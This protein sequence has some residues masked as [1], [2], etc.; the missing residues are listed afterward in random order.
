M[1]L[2]LDSIENGARALGLEL[3][4]VKAAC[5]AV[6]SEL[7]AG[8]T[9]GAVLA[10][11]HR[12]QEWIYPVGYADPAPERQI[13]VN[14]DTLYD[15]ASLT[16]VVATLPLILGLIDEGILTL[17]T[18][19]SSIVPDF[20][21]AGKEEVTVGELLTHTSG[22]QAHMNLHSH[23]W[24]KEQMW[25]AVHQATLVREPRTAV[26]YSDL[27]YL[28]L[29]RVIEQVLGMSIGEAARIRIFEPLEMKHTSFSPASDAGNGFAATEYDEVFGRHLYGIVHDE[30]ARALDGGCGHA[31]LFASSRDLMRYAQM[32][33]KGGHPVLSKAAVNTSIRSHTSGV[34][35]A[36]RGLGWVLKGDRMDASGDLMSEQCYGHTGFT[37]TSLW[38]DPAYNL[39]VVLLTNR[40]YGGRSGSV[41]SLRVRVHN[42]LTAAVKA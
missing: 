10:V 34:S 11:V 39:A 8:T 20:G 21:A 14:E 18:T 37:G 6:H 1:S 22:L 32:W 40:V 25:E 42:A 31:G 16:K 30:N 24:S 4:K 19:I 28:M 38:I 36:N 12:G 9:P 35:D 7:E 15:C 27:G 17:G 3:E 29:G 26:V 13:P 5:R 33:L 23:G 2:N 41:A